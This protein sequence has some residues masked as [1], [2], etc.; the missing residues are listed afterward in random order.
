MKKGSQ[1]IKEAFINN[2]SK[3]I[4]NT[5]TDG[6]AVYYHGHK[7]IEKRPDGIYWTLAGYNT[8]STKEKVNTIAN[9]CVFQKN[10]SL[11]VGDK[12]IDPCKWYKSE[13]LV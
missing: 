2:L 3:K 8:V 1:Q 7:I 10:Y 4:S 11:F 13:S 6:K 12:E 9:A 5:E